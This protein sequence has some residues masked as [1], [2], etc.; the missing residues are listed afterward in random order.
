M[1]SKTKKAVLISAL[2][3]L[4]ALLLT[5]IGYVV[6]VFADYYRLE[7]NIDMSIQGNTSLSVPIGEPLTLVSYNIGF[8]AYSDDY[9][10]FMDGGKYSRAFSRE[11]VI[12]NTEGA[13]ASALAAEPDFILFQEV[14]VDGTRSY[15]YDQ[16]SHLAGGIADFESTFAQNYDSPYLFYPFTSPI[17]ANR[18]GLMT[19]SRYDISSATRRSL[20]IEDSLYKLLDLDRAYT[21]SVI[22]ISENGKCLYLYNVHL[23]A[24][25]SDGTIADEQL[26]MLV[27]DMQEK[28]EAGHYTVAA[29]DFNKDLLGNSGE[30]FTRGGED[31]YT[32]AKPLDTSLL[33]DF[34][35][36]HSGKNL[37]T[38]RNADSPYRGDGTDFV[39]SVDGMLV[40]SNVTVICCET[41][42]VGFEY[43]DHNPV[44]LVFQLEE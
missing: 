11:A 5:V 37:P 10:F 44:K 2:S 31:D 19:F 29:G 33:P 38:C 3:L 6:Y 12:E 43:S 16:T 23:S 42:D 22:P 13:L 21:V 26:K 9:S 41:L 34:L 35:S 40:S 1:T 32:W 17:G 14:D 15:H 28:Y 18:S 27:S 20:P 7:D 4:G 36:C 39:L 24:Y 25:T 8:G 30:Y